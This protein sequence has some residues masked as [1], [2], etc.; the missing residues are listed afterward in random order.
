MTWRPLPEDCDSDAVSVRA[1]LN[2]LATKLGVP[3]ASIFRSV[4]ARWPEVVG[5]DILEHAQPRSLVERVLSVAVDDPRWATQLKWLGPQLV[6]RLNDAVGEDAI[7]R[8]EVRLEGARPGSR[9]Q[10]DTPPW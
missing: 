5:D 2:R 9:P 10:G 6:N 3:S 4:L 1:V 8:I 7:D